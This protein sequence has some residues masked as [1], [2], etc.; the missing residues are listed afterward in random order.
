MHR[1]AVVMLL[2][3]GC[4][5]GLSGPDPDQPR[6]KVPQ[7][8]TGKGLVALDAVVAAT[9]GVVALGLAGET[10]P[11]VALVPLAIGSLYVAGALR[12]N[13]N[14]NKC[15]KAMGEY[16]TYMASRDTLRAI[17]NDEDIQ[18][19][20]VTAR[21]EQ[22]ESPAAS[23]ASPAPAPVAPPAAPTPAP[24]AAP[25][26]KSVAKPAPVPAAQDDEWSEFWREVD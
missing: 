7:C 10:E 17:E 18:R 26:L 24:A 25:T 8:D 5:F 19:R 15:R 23:P 13:S 3:S 16:E 2:Y 9:A 22:P 20:P 21:V 12:G 11:E 14:V 4:A 6:S 1:W